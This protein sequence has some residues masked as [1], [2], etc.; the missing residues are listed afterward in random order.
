MEGKTNFSGAYRL[1][2]TGIVECLDIIDVGCDLKQ[3]DGFT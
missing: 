3:F 1:T 2:G